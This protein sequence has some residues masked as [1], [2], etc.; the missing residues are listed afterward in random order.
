MSA[1]SPKRS[2]PAGWAAFLRTSQGWPYLLVPFIPLAIVLDLAHAGAVVVFF[3]SALGVIP[4]AALMGR[5]T[6][7]LA[8][9]SG[10]GIGGLLNVTFGNAP[11]LIIALFALQKGLHEVVKASIIGSIIGNVLLVLGA[12]MFA[13]GLKGGRMRGGRQRFNRTS[14]SAQSA[15]LLLAATALVM[16]AIYELVVGKGLPL[17]GD[18]I[19]NYEPKVET[20]SLIVALVLIAS[21][22]AGLIFSLRTHRDLFNPEGSEEHEGEPWSVRRS[23]AML[24][25]AGVAVGGMSEILVGSISEA[26]HSIGLTE[27]FVGAIVVAI[28]GNAAEHW[29]AV[30]VAVKDKMDLAVNI[31]IGSSAQIALFVAPVLVLLSFV[32]GPHP[33]AL[34]FNGFELGAVLLAVLI[35]NQVTQEGESNWFEGLQLLAVY[36]VIALTFA[37]A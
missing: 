26:A 22:V 36:A 34:V 25:L 30:L 13:G 4:T 20:L 24:A 18:E 23:V 33:M 16:P 15:M 7:E 14:A 9:R 21:Y 6:E 37:F 32:L 5:A 12:A 31:S 1:A 19:V 27:F 28:V 11:E 29:V 17:P 3:T 2:G 8:A 35:A 10:P